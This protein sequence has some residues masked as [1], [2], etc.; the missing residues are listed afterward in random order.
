MTVTPGLLPIH[1][2]IRVTCDYCGGEDH[3]Q[4]YPLNRCAIVSCRRCGFTFVNPRYSSRALREKLQFWAEQDLVDGER[5]RIA[6]E[7]GTLRLFA[8][9][10]RRLNR[11]AEGR[12]R[13]LLDVGCSTGAFLRVAREG[14]WEVE[15]LEAGRA[16]SRYAREKLGLTIHTSLLED[17]DMPPGAYDAIVLLEVLE[18]LE[19]PSTALRRI[20]R[21]LRPGGLLLLSTPNYDSLYRRLHGSR[22]WV[23]NCEDEHIMLFTPST[24]G[25]LLRRCGYR[26]EWAHIRG[27]D[28]AG[29]AAQ[30]VAR[31]DKP[32]SVA[33]TGYHGARGRKEQIKKLLSRTG[34]LS[35]VRFGL[36]ALDAAFSHPS[37]PFFGLGEQLVVIARRTEEER[38]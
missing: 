7:P 25:A 3:V 14:G 29:I 33:S 38:P 8:S 15:G 10:V 24:L 36:R 31:R 6:F 26:V 13:K 9:Y 35:L 5:L 37:S 12:R 4:R 21:W 18:H 19:S 17:F 22:W 32:L 16:S 27:I 20:S 23:V 1:D 11:M 30:F 28:A 2:L 34:L